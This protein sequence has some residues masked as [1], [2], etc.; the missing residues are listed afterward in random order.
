MPPGLVQIRLVSVSSGS[1]PATEALFDD[2]ELLVCASSCGVV[3]IRRHLLVW[4]LH[5]VLR[6]TA[7][8]SELHHMA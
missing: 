6:R 5:V 2:N 3:R 7:A 4:H 1:I 8:T